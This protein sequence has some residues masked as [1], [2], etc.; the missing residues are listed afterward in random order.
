[1]KKKLLT[2]LA[3]VMAAMTAGAFTLTTGTSEHG[4]LAFKVQGVEVTEASEGDVVTVVCTPS[5]GY[6]ANLPSGE[7]SA[8]VAF[9]RRRPVGCR[10]PGAG[11]HPHS[12]R[13]R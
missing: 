13:W 7:W 5:T 11:L 10:H 4:T 8:G 12:R 3:F 2:L 1:M 9:A 6:V